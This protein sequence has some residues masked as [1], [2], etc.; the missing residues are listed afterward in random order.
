LIFRSL[1]GAR[2][3]FFYRIS[4]KMPCLESAWR[5]WAFCAIAAEIMALFMLSEARIV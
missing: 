1:A 4:D 2:A 3:V 5:S